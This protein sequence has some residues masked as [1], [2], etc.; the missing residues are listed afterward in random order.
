METQSNWTEFEQATFFSDQIQKKKSFGP[1]GFL[2]VSF[3]SES[4]RAKQPKK[5]FLLCNTHVFDLSDGTVRRLV[6]VVVVVV[7][8]ECFASDI[9]GWKVNQGKA[10]RTAVS[11]KDQGN[12]RQF[13]CLNCV[14]S[15]VFTPYCFRNVIRSVDRTAILPRFGHGWTSKRRLVEFDGVKWRGGRFGTRHIRL[16]SISCGWRLVETQTL[17][18]SYGRLSDPTYLS[19]RPKMWPFLDI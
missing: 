1:A 11:L 17:L 10:S 16:T 13:G 18:G 7:G 14:K 8:G 15:I 6:V 3:R 5:V 19:L 4:E 2:R 9:D 12:E